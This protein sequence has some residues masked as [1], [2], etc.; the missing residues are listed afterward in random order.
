MIHICT[1]TDKNFLL[2]GLALYQSLLNSGCEFELHWLCIDNETFEKLRKFRN[3]GIKRYELFEL[4]DN[5]L[6]LLKSQCNPPSKYAANER[7]QFIWC[8]TPYFTN[9][10]LKKIPENEY[11][12]YID[13]DICLYENPEKLLDIIS[14]MSVGIHSH[15]FEGQ[16]TENRDTGWF[17]V[18]IVVFKNDGI[19]R[20]ISMIWKQWLLTP[21]IYHEKYGT[22]GD[23]KYLELFIKLW[24]KHHICIFDENIEHLAPW[25]WNREIKQSPFFFHFSD[26]ETSNY[27]EKMKI[28][29]SDYQEL[30]NHSKKLLS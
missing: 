7:E 21:G 14:P 24:P 3:L 13:S 22:C 25:N 1:L 16:Y 23:Q 2:K 20:H 8:L 17:N 26:F 18:G 10:I 4:L 6:D 11:L 15:K 19:G 28:Y 30:L 29:Q 9:Y 27:P 5:D 12:F